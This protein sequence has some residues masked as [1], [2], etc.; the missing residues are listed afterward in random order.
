MRKG[1]G[2]QNSSARVE[3]CEQAEARPGANEAARVRVP[4]R[5]RICF[6]PK[7]PV[8]LTITEMQILSFVEHHEGKSY[9]KAQIAAAL[10]RNEKTVSRL[11]SRL[12]QYQIL[13]TEPSF[14]P[15]GAQLANV[16]RIADPLP[17]DESGSFPQSHKD[18]PE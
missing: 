5:M 15:S 6:T 12:R 10:G 14:A 18:S 11:I 1:K 4:A 2:L 17:G 13:E 3:P 16:Y 9:S 7:G 8:R